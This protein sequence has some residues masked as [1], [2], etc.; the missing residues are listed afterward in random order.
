MKKKHFKTL[1]AIFAKP[2]NGNIKWQD[3]ESLLLAC[4]ATI[5]PSGKGMKISLGGQKLAYHRP[6]GRN[7]AG[8]GLVKR[9]RRLLEDQEVTR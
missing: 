3:I 1:A 5:T 6:H 2:T 4:G 9:V 8:E 7:N